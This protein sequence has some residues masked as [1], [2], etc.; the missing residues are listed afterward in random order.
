MKN[1]ALLFALFFVSLM[2]NAD[3]ES[4][5]DFH[6]VKGA[7]E[8]TFVKDLEIGLYQGQK[9]SEEIEQKVTALGGNMAVYDKSKTTSMLWHG[10][11]GSSGAD[12][13]LNVKAYSCE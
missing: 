11:D 13:I 4:A 5:I 10:T 1:T 2:A 6:F 7:S 3:T 12:I 8:C 9:L